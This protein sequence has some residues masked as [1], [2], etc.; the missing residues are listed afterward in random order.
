MCERH[1]DTPPEVMNEV[2]DLMEALRKSLEKAIGERDALNP[3]APSPEKG[4]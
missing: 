1:E 2:I 4:E 3:P